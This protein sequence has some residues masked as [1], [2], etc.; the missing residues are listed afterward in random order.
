M[1]G[2]LMS[3][4]DIQVTNSS[5]PDIEG[6]IDTG[7]SNGAW[8]STSYLIG[9]II[10]IPL[11]DYLSRVFGFRRFFLAATALFLC[12]SVG[13]AFA[14][15]L[16]QMIILRGLQGF[17]A[18]AMVPMAMTYVLAN[19]PP[20]QLPIGIAI[21]AM[22][23]TF[24]P[25]I[26][27]TLGGYLTDTFGWKYV[28]FVNLVPGALMFALLLPTLQRESMRLALLRQGDWAGIAFMA[29]GL[30]CLQT[31][32]DQGNQY[33]W[34]T[35]DFIVKL[36]IIAAV[37]LSIFIVIE[38]S[39]D[40]PLVNLRLL[41]LRNFGLGTVA[42]VIV[43]FAMFGAIYVL[44]TYLDETQGYNALQVGQVMA[45]SGI[46]QLFIIPFLPWLIK[47][48]DARLI[49][50]V[51]LALFASSC[52]MNS[53]LSA[54]FGG[55]EM[56]T[57]NIIRA[58]GQALLMAPLSL[59]A[60]YGITRAQ[61]A[62]ASGLF[63]MLRSLGGAFGTA[64]LATIVTT[65]SDFHS[66]RIAEARAPNTPMVESFL[67]QMQQ[68]FL[69]SGV[70]QD[71]ARAMAMAKD[72]LA[73]MVQKQ[74]LIMGYSDAFYIMGMVLIVAIVFV[75]PTHPVARAIALPSA[76]EEQVA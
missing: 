21:F 62:Q 72:S 76:T 26:G 18:G 31:V 74:G 12:F 20:R 7:G 15:S 5:L 59:I 6:G 68:Y 30:A 43:G 46:P 60:L 45:W 70:T 57:S 61:S 13:C 67:S 29:V 53:A 64:I 22:T 66:Q 17:S 42:N 1:L 23:A 32:L 33:N 47:R 34:F 11:A 24:G 73:D 39:I 2:A 41:A 19:L 38:M 36:A 71:S 50:C 58:V 55:D 3:V 49:V 63:N 54:N 27:P 4:L 69:S 44:P 75:L 10:M 25:A 9:E 52:F 16:P 37:C 65:R 28:F 35:S 14:V 8:I 48:V 40:R 51:G 56:R